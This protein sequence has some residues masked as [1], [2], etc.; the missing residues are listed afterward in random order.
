MNISGVLVHV[1][2]ENLSFNNF[3]PPNELSTTN[4]KKQ[5]I[6]NQFIMI[7]HSLWIGMMNLKACQPIDEAS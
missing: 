3:S 2:P 7:L 1:N 5:R 6:R 4:F